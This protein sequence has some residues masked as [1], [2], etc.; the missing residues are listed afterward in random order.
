MRRELSKHRS[1]SSSPT[2]PRSLS[3]YSPPSAEPAPSQHH[4]TKPS[5]TDPTEAA[6]TNRTPHY[7]ASS[8]SACDG[9]NPPATTSP[10]PLA[11]GKTKRETIRCLKRYLARE[12]YTVLCPPTLHKTT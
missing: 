10:D 9:T 3:T 7:T 6:T 1:T 5:D 12:I 8:R 4:Q 2:Q 11:E